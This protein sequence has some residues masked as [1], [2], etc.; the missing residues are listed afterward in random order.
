M[1]TQRKGVVLITG[2]SSGIGQAC[3]LR[4][5]EQGYS[6]YG[7]SRRAS[8]DSQQDTLSMI[9]M[10]VTS[11]ASVERG[12]DL[13]LA[14]EGRIDVVVNN[15]GIAVAGAIENTSMDEALEQLDVNFFGAV[16]VCRAAL[17]IMRR[18]QRG[19]IVNIGS[20]GGLIGIPYQ[21]MYSA[22]KFALEGFTESLRLEARPFG[23]RVA[24]IEPGDHKTPLTF[25]RR[26]AVGSQSDRVY[27]ASFEAAIESMAHDEQNGPAP[28]GI[29]RLL[30]RIV[31][32]PNPRLRYTIGPIA[33]RA[34][35]FMKR[36][37][38][39]AV[40]EYGMRAYYKLS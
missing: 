21:A 19:Y 28:E 34:A 18:Q 5:A 2:A 14:R 3:G 13:V 7:T 31:E 22:S 32:T 35:V 40:T 30:H 27:R 29:A 23:I 1:T 4:L 24:L 12:V 36:L 16:R 33:Q 26:R 10:D 8:A 25:N 37:L 6:V 39:Y 38:P 11:D 20:I 15:S 17:P 9:A